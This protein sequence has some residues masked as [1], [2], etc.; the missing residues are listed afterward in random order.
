VSFFSVPESGKS[1]AFV[2]LIGYERFVE[3]MKEE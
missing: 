3:I 1:L 2:G